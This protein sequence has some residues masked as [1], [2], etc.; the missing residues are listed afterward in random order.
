MRWGINSKHSW[1]PGFMR[2]VQTGDILWFVK[3]KSGGLVI[4]VATFTRHCEREL[5]PLIAATPTNQE[6]GWVK[7][8]GDWD[9]EVHYTDLY[10]IEDCDIRT[11]IKSPLT[12]RIYNPAKCVVDL[13]LEYAN[14][15]RYSMARRVIIRQ[16]EF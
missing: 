11:H 16:P 14:I 1:A 6:L 3:A 4:G 5:G 12:G 13:P 2:T 9:T 10:N 7:T 8:P 15:V